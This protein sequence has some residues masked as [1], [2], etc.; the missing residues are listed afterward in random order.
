M[1]HEYMQ[2]QEKGV[3]NLGVDNS[4]SI[5]MHLLNAKQKVYDLSYNYHGGKNL[6]RTF[7]IILDLFVLNDVD[8]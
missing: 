6:E 4:Q 8:R 2:P 1:G 5:S 3:F 7:F